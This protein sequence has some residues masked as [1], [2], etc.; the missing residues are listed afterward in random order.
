MRI[1]GVEQ[2][3]ALGKEVVVPA[4]VPHAWWTLVSSRHGCGVEF[5][6]GTQRRAFL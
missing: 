3:L 1:G 6:P 2:N 5:R 4:G